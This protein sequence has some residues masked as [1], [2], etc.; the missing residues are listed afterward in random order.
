MLTNALW[1]QT[2]QS[3]VLVRVHSTD[4]DALLNRD[5]VDRLLSCFSASVDNCL[6]FCN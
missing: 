5:N 1:K 6:S 2:D 4:Q 3:M